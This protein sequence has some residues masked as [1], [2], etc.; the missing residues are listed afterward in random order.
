MHWTVASRGPWLSPFVPGDRHQFDFVTV[1][2]TR[3]S[4]H[5]RKQA[6]TA[7][8]EWV[9]IWAHASEVWRRQHGGIITLFP[10]TATAVGLRKRLARGKAPVVAYNFNL[11][12]LYGGA[13]RKLAQIALSSVNRLV[14]HA[15]RECQRYA[16]WLGLPRDRFQFIP[17]QCGTIPITLTEDVDQPF[18]LA[19]GSAHRDYKSLF[20]AV[21]PLELRTLVVAGPHALQGLSIPRCVEVRSGLPMKECRELAQRARLCVVPLANNETASG[22]VTVVEAMRM[23]RPV[24]ATEC[25]G[26]EDYIQSGTTGLLVPIHSPAALA[27]AISRLWDD[28]ELRSQFSAHGWR[29]ANDHFSDEAAGVAL[30]QILDELS[31]GEA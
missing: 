27:H 17:L 12:Q 29:Y 23:G 8:S 24:I 9:N 14:V 21:G 7:S 26:T 31:Q 25:I 11:G 20:E 6:M 3:E 30:G 15:H 2:Q 10:Q 16:D 5:T 18:L 19:M 13:K 28:A 22:Q 4:W 1:P